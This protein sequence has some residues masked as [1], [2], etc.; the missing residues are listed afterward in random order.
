MIHFRERLDLPYVQT[1]PVNFSSRAIASSAPPELR[2]LRSASL[3]VQLG[4]VLPPNGHFFV[5]TFEIPPDQKD[6]LQAR[7]QF[8]RDLSHPCFDKLVIT[9]PKQLPFAQV[10]HRHYES[11]VVG[12]KPLTNEQIARVILFVAFDMHYLHGHSISVGNLKANLFWARRFL[13][14]PKTGGIRGGASTHRLLD[15]LLTRRSSRVPDG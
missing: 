15:V 6:A 1:N 5:K 12:G 9:G 4:Q 3:V 13:L 8:V 10:W 11:L 2:A 14:A 7:V